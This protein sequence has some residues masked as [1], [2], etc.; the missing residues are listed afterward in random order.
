MTHKHVALEPTMKDLRM[1]IRYARKRFPYDYGDAEEQ[2]DELL[3]YVRELE[4][5]VDTYYVMWSNVESS[6]DA[7]KLI[8]NRPEWLQPAAVK[9]CEKCGELQAD[10][11]VFHTCITS[12]E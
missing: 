9:H 5:R 7:L 6:M 2:Y 3:A 11:Q 4:D 10:G 12:G 1:A 8:T